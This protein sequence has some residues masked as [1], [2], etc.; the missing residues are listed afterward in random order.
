MNHR[1]V[2]TAIAAAGATLILG[3]G[4]AFAASGWTIVS[5]PP[6]GENA[7]LSGVSEVSATDAWAVGLSNAAPNGLG[8]KPVIDNW[9][10]AA[11]SQVTVTAP[12]STTWLTAVNASSATDAWAVGWTEPQR[13]TIH[14]L[15][16]HWNG[17][18]W[19]VSA[20][21]GTALPNDTYMVGV[22]DISPTDAYAVGDN[23]AYASGYLEH[24]NGTTWSKVTYPLPAGAA[25][26]TTLNA[27]S[28]NGP[29]DVWIVGGYLDS[30]NERNE[31]FSDHWNG[32]AW[33]LVTMP[34]VTGSSNLLT[35]Q[36]NSI[37][38]NSPTDVWA[39]GGSGDNAL[40]QGGSPSTTL[41]EHWNGSAWSIVPSPS[42]GTNDNLSGVTTSNA[43]DSV[44]AVGYD[45]P[46]GAT[47][48]QT[49]TLNWNGT[50]WTTV[51][52]PD[53][54]SSSQ[55]DAASTLPGSSTVWAVGSSGASGSANPLVLQNG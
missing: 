53:N 35:Y 41:I 54:G 28:A 1:R 42:P 40:E 6:A 25:S 44:W 17:T 2:A 52:S 45:T 23:S 51:A 43:S 4:P 36:F 11:W 34:L 16:M 37:V 33:S 8:A 39:V 5:A 30:A 46:S 3:V 55:L 10:G 29:D 49:L 12:S 19:S 15:A 26:N 48:P 22:A 14:P 38:A 20:S 50:A 21:G 9:N 24:W 7:V 32:S 31:T 18:A 27:I 47:A 13:Y